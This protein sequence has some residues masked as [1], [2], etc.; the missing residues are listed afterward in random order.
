MSRI[1]NL[2]KWLTLPEAADHLSSALSEPVSVPDILRLALEGHIVISANFVNHC[3]VTLGRKVAIEEAQLTLVASLSAIP[4]SDAWRALTAGF[5]KDGTREEQDAWLRS[6]RVHESGEAIVMLRGEAISET[7]V[8]EWRKAVTTIEGVWDLP[9]IGGAMIDV[10]DIL[11]HLTGGPQVELFP[12]DGVILVSDDR[13]MYAKIMEHYSKNPYAKGRDDPAMYPVN[14][15]RSYYPVVRLPEDAPLVVR[16][17]AI[18]TFLSGLLPEEPAKAE[19]GTREKNGLLRII[20]GLAEEAKVDLRSDKA[21]A[22]IVAAA[23]KFDGPNE[24]TVRKHVAA[25]REEI[26]GGQRSE[27]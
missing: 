23:A 21:T 19:I 20:A 2:K 10:E 5:P 3:H 17:S 14:D 11:Q 6:S 15:Y 1:F 16:P 27:R 22:Q 9:L 25:I 24:K 7:E 18:A 12:L 13:T 4:G 26:L 8:L